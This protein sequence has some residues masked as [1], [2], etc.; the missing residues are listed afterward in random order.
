MFFLFC[1]EH[2]TKKKLYLFIFFKLDFILIVCFCLFVC[3]FVNFHLFLFT[4][5]C[6]C[7]NLFL[8]F[9]VSVSFLTMTKPKQVYSLS[10]TRI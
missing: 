9:Y 4:F 6:F 2:G 10:K 8:S 3:L 1:H 7:S 5:V